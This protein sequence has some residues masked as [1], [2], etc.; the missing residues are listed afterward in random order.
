MTHEEARQINDAAHALVRLC[1]R[2]DADDALRAHAV[3][4]AYMSDTI[5]DAMAPANIKKDK[6][7]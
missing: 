2:Y 4:A 7:T 1:R 6:V 5:V 3:N